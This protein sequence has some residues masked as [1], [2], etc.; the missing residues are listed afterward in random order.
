MSLLGLQ[1]HSRNPTTTEWD[2]AQRRI[3]NLPPLEEPAPS[4]AEEK[5]ADAVRV[6]ER[7]GR[8][9]AAAA[10]DEPSGEAAE[11][12]QLRAKRLEELQRAGRFGSL[13]S[14]THAQFVAEVNHAAEDVGVVVFLFKKGHYA[15]AYMQTLLE[16]LAA[17]FRDVKFVTIGHT[18]CIPDYPDCNLPTL[19]I[20]RNDD[21]L[22]QCVG[23]AAFGGDAYGIDDVEWELADASVVR[24]ELARN[25]HAQ[26]HR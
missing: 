26:R 3:G 12:A 14:I 24:T 6:A 21:L 5:L 20:Y 2:D 19:L 25:P 8:S 7:Y 16:K 15:S 23:T 22:K 13:V 9:E 11:L 1:T 18:E 10:D 17:R 4:A